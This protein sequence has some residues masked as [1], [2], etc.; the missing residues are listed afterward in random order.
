MVSG[1][2]A[3]TVI[4]DAF[5]NENFYPSFLSRYQQLWMEEFGKDLRAFARLQDRIKDAFCLL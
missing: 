5:E 1:G 3:A 4:S 2:N